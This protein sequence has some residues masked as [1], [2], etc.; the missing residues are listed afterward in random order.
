[1]NNEFK[2]EHNNE[3]TEIGLSNWFVYFMRDLLEP[4]L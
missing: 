4:I 1:M 3:E 2:L